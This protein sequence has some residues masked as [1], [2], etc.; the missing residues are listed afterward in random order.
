MRSR[1]ITKKDFLSSLLYHSLFNCFGFFQST[2]QRAFLLSVF[3]SG[4][5]CVE[6]TP[7]PIPNTVV[8]LYCADDTGFTRESR[9]SPVYALTYRDISQGFFFDC[10]TPIGERV[11]VHYAYNQVSFTILLHAKLLVYFAA[12]RSCISAAAYVARTLKYS[13]LA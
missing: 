8:K 2:E 4:D 5:Y 10:G 1:M 7:V 9:K 13:I 6:V 11:F 12:T 3:D